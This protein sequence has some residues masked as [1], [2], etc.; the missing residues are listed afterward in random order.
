MQTL[1]E[2]EAADE[3]GLK[4]MLDTS[5]DACARFGVKSGDRVL[6]MGVEAEVAGV[7]PL[8]EDTFCVGKGEKVLWVIADGNGDKISFVSQLHE[9]IKL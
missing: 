5:D 8:P 6:A 2:F 1:K 7:A 3:G 9:M 4:I